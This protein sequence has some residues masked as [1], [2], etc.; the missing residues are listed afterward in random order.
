[1]P[2]VVRDGSRAPGFSGP[3]RSP[4]AGSRRRE[5]H[6]CESAISRVASGLQWVGVMWAAFFV[7]GAVYLIRNLIE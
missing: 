2:S 4:A 3:G 7:F 6:W 5:S 1:M